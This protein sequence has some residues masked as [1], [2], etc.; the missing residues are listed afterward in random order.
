M[1]IRD[2]SLF[3]EVM[4]HGDPLLL[5][6]GGPG[7]DHWTMAPF[8]RLADAFTVVLYD[9]RCNGR[10]EGAPVESM[11]WDNLTADADALRERLG[12]DRSSPPGQPR[13]RSC[14]LDRRIADR[15]RA[16]LAPTRRSGVTQSMG[17]FGSGSGR[18]ADATVGASPTVAR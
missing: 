7:A 1:P 11:T 10:S 6:H 4:G 14:A 15:R 5:M 17:P 18:G 2:V 12:F 8:R 3:V 13:L 16:P 9:H